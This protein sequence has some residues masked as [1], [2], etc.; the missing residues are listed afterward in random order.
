MISENKRINRQ[1]ARSLSATFATAFLTLSLVI[2]LASGSMQLLFNIQ[3]QQRALSSQQQIIAQNA[4]RTVSS[5]IE[6]HFSVLSTSVWVAHPDTLSSTGQ[7]Q[8]LQNLLANQ[9]AFRQFAIFDAQNNE[10]ASGSR[11]Q[12]TATKSISSYVTSDILAQTQKGQRYISSVYFDVANNE[13]LVLMAVPA[14]NALG[15]FQGTLVGE[16]NLISMWNL[17]AQIQV[18]NTGYAYVVDGKGKLI[19]FKDTA[20]ALKGEDTGNIK[21]VNEF[22]HNVYA[23][24]TART[25]IYTGI[26]GAI[27]V[28]T[29]V[30]LG[31]P[32]WAVV[33]ELPWQEAYRE[34]IQVGA[35]S[36]G[37]ILLLGVLSVA[38]GVLLARRL[39]IPLIELTGTAT[40]IASGDLKS[41]ALLKGGR[42]INALASAFNN[43]ADQMQGLISS[44]EERVS[45]RTQVLE[46]HTR[47]LQNAA[48]IVREVSALQNPDTLLERVAYLIREKFG[49]YHSGI[50]LIDKHEE[51]A[52]LKAAGGDAGRLMLASK[53][54]LRIGETGIVGY[55]A[56]TG[57][58]RIALDV[59]ADAVH[60]Q[61]PLLP[62]TRSEMALPLKTANRVIGVLDIQSDKT[63]AFDQS[64]ISV[65]QIVTEQ[66]SIGLERAQLLQDMQ[67]NT[68]SLQLM[69]QENTSRTWR[70]F[71]EQEPGYVGYQYDGVTIESVKE[72]PLDS[73]KVMQ[74]GGSTITMKAEKGRTG[75]TLAVP[76]RLRGQT[77][78]ILNL[79]FQTSEVSQDTLRLVEEAA[80][81]LALALENARLVQDAQRLAMRERQINVISSQVQQS[82]NLEMLLQN[83]VRELGNSLGTPKAFIQIG[84]RQSESKTDH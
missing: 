84:L 72:L 28:G 49:Y 63:N 19:A 46:K 43:M 80:N 10:S 54:K 31:T 57:E 18:G 6:D 29:Y 64:D 8:F 81:R 1:P 73:L 56:K 42:E 23:S 16:L 22:I 33:T 75:N 55:V 2:L 76:I 21:S 41:R 48:Q 39:S 5:F 3:A 70:N 25:S 9:P 50:F 32:N 67:Q 14:I 15:I 26:T 51:Y 12:M 13:P 61:N 45:D 27:V 30:P 52:V 17:V 69:L 58:P 59:G 60:F 37:I 66:L 78:G 35:A 83:T 62:Y 47:E 79:E 38:A 77:L 24:P 40:S 4:A 7:I 34:T 65:M 53:H 20:R 44:L 74:D 36:I 68:A 11:T 71:L 82:T